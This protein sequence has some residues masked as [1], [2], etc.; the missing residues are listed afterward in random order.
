[1]TPVDEGYLQHFEEVGSWKTQKVKVM[2]KA[3]KTVVDGSAGLEELEIAAKEMKMTEK[4]RL[5]LP[6]TMGLAT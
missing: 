5:Y 4:A 6:P 2:E 3:R 1:M